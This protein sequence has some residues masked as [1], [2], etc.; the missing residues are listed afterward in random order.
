M[1]PERD[2][3]LSLWRYCTVFTL[4][5]CPLNVVT[6]SSSATSHSTMV[7]SPLAVNR[8]FSPTVHSRS[9]TAFVWLNQSVKQQHSCGSTKLANISIRVAQPIWQ[10]TAFVWLNQSG[11]QQ[12]SC[13][14]TNL[15]NN[16]IRVAQPIWQTTVF[17]WLNQSGKQQHLCGSTNL[18]NYGIRVAQPIWQTT[19]F[20][21]LNHLANNSIR[22]AQP[23]WQT[24]AF[25]WLNQSDKQQHSC[26]CQRHYCMSCVLLASDNVYPEITWYEIL[27]RT[28]TLDTLSSNDCT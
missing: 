3:H 17:M 11:K 8:L 7:W 25:V 21:W 28:E 2:L 6:F 24:T 16:G 12:H 18:A 10:T 13:G 4:L 23:I 9:N 5:V 27:L 26:D 22:V 14:S 20:V 19:A 1:H 15:A